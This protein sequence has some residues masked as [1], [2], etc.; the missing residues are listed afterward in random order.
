MNKV[1][2]V[3]YLNEIIHLVLPILLMTLAQ[4]GMGVVDTVVSSLSSTTDVAAIGL[5]T[6]IWN[7]IF[8]ST[9][10]MLS[11]LT[12]VNSG[13]YAQQQNEKSETAFVQ[14][15]IISLAISAII[16]LFLCYSNLWLDYFVAEEKIKKITSVY[17]LF[18]APSI[19]FVTLFQLFRSDLEAQK[20]VKNTMA[21]YI[22]GLLINI[23]LSLFFALGFGAFSGYGAVGCGI[24][25]SIAFFFM[26]LFQYLVWKKKAKHRHIKWKY[27]FQVLKDLIKLGLPM[28]ASTAMEIGMFSVVTLLIAYYGEAVLAGHQITMSITSTIFSIP[29]SIA[30]ALTILIAR[31]RE[32]GNKKSIKSIA[33]TGLVIGFICILTTSTITI[34]FSKSVVGWYTKETVVIKFAILFILWACIYQIFDMFQAVSIGILRGFSDTAKPFVYMLVSSWLVA[35]PVGYGLSHY[36]YKSPI[37]FYQGLLV[38]LF[39][40]CIALY[41]RLLKKLSEVRN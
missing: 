1:F 9:T 33:L 39:V 32:V 37:G 28:G 12:I 11:A 18:I 30:S 13:Y 35:I 21:I 3:Y 25:T 20:C 24:A 10:S 36:I 27:D 7:P 8:F 41:F 2:K 23:P 17:L 5:G 31:E 19:L 26:M 22:L 6:A 4:L 16:I 38:G 40:V 15:V 34:Y 14:S 29:I